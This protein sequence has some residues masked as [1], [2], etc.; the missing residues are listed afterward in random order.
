M[1]SEELEQEQQVFICLNCVSYLLHL[2]SP[3]PF[4]CV[5]YSSLV[6]ASCPVHLCLCLSLGS[7]LPLR[8]PVSPPVHL[9]LLAWFIC[10]PPTRSLKCLYS[11][12]LCLPPVSLQASYS[13]F[14]CVSPPGFT[15]ASF[16]STVS[17]TPFHLPLP[18]HLCLLAPAHLCLWPRSPV[19]PICSPVSPTP[20]T[21]VSPP[22]HPG[23]PPVHT[24]VSGPVHS[25]LPLRSHLC[26]P[27]RSPVFSTPFICASCLCLTPVSLPCS[28]CV[29]PSVHPGLLNSVYS[30]PPAQ[31]QS[32]SP[33][34]PI[35]GSSSVHLCLLTPFTCA[36]CP[37]LSVSPCPVHLCSCPCSPV[38]PGP[39]HSGVPT[40]FTPG[41]LLRLPV[42]STPFTCS[43]PLR[44]LQVPCPVHL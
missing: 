31:V 28:I 15:Q 10:V 34:C 41:L 18:V 4:T 25:S 12:Q 13:G 26:L 21:C 33:V 19:S 24:C 7:G 6:C 1:G 20:F 40:P 23:L 8:S 5:F 38:S 30:V 36:S 11:V 39:V 37:V 14:T 3:T 43:S 16:C 2:V 9:C 42:S 32:V 35:S 22:V 17:P 29:S 27:L 44:S